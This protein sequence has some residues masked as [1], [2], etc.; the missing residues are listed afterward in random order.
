[1]FLEDY[2]FWQGH[3][4]IPMYDPWIALAAMAMRTTQVALGTTVTPLPR[5]RP[6]KLAKEMV[7]LDHLS[8][9]RMILGIGLGDTVT[10]DLSFSAVGEE[11]QV[12]RR[13][14]MLDEALEVI[15][16][17]WGGKAFL[18]SGE[19]FRVE[20]SRFLPRPVQRPRIPIW[21][22]GGYP[23]KGPTARAARYDGAIMYKQGSHVMSPD[24][25]RALAAGIKEKRGTLKGYDICS[26]GG[27]RGKNWDKE[28]DHIR[29]VGEAGVTWWSEYIPPT[30][31][32]FEA[33]S[34]LLERGPLQIES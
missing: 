26:G 19:F 28:R 17:L 30:A 5:R 25:I 3:A 10:D 6:W 22:G 16:G 8:G 9:G 18:Y 14:K 4:K 21:V 23:L 34:K 32:D 33:I 15:T 12:K 24:D 31:G 13:A 20:V 27:P 7:T 2:I 11:M 1:V 29:A